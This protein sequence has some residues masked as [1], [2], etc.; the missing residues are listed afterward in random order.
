MCDYVIVLGGGKLLAQGEI[1]ELKQVHEQTFRSAAQGRHGVVRRAAG[2]AGLRDRVRTTTCSAC[3]FR[4]G[5]RRSCCGKRRPHEQ[6]AD[7]LL[8]AAAQHARRSVL[9]CR[10]ASVMPIFDQGYQHWS[11]QLVGPRLAL[12]GDHAA[13]RADR[14][15]KAGWFGWC[16]FVAW[17]PAIVLAF[18]LCLWGLAGAAIRAD[19]VDH[20]DAHVA[21][22]PADS[23]R[24][25]RVPRRNLDDLLPL[26]PVVGVVVLDGAHAA[27]GA[28]SDQPGPALQRA[29][30]VFLAAAAADR[31]FSRQAGRDRGA[32]G[33]W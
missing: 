8:A 19:R 5:S 33:G 17:L 30:A 20:A 24:A 14:H 26:F 28:E 21:S 31:L 12:A 9:E 25:A 13:R 18:V 23:G 22:R 4:P 1:Q 7:S 29:A 10:G 6:R 16:L 2:G 27:R 15:C 32:F 3:E 11:G